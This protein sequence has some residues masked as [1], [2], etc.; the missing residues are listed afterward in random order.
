MNSSE[1]T[2][3]LVFDHLPLPVV[4]VNSAFDFTYANPAAV[5]WLGD[6]L[7]TK[8]VRDLVPPNHWLGMTQQ[9]AR[10]QRG[11]G[12]FYDTQLKQRDGQYVPVKIA[13]IPLV[14]S[15]GQHIGSV[16]IVQN[17]LFDD[18]AEMIHEAIADTRDG[19]ELL[20]KVAS[21]AIRLV[22]F[23]YF[24]V[25]RYSVDLRHT[26]SFHN[27]VSSGPKVTRDV[28]WWK[29]PDP[30]RHGIHRPR[31]EKDF[32]TLMAHAE[33]TEFREHPTVK[34]FLAEGYRSFLRLPVFTG[35]RLVAALILFSRQQ[36]LYSNKSIDT[37]RRLPLEQAV[38]TALQYHEFAEQ[39]FRGTLLRSL[40]KCQQPKELADLLVAELAEQY[41][42]SHV[43]VFRIDEAANE[44]RLLAQHSATGIRMD[45]DYQQAL[46]DGVLGHVLKTG[47]AVNIPDVR[48]TEEL[49]FTPRVIHT[50]FRSE[51]CLPIMRD[52]SAAHSHAAQCR[53]RDG[54]CLFK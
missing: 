16:G 3:T 15:E 38:Q 17:M 12:G 23:D 33:L 7:L 47:K 26:M 6:D 53:R 46:D 54:K 19:H 13:G 18:V 44:F 41:G 2:E 29:I 48:N 35:G 31:V 32:A 1:Q 10:R 28:R 49:A 37:L 45:S 34:K 50:H 14:N 40:L 5:E 24:G 52:N 11:K 27:Y 21:A 39:R 25:S 20:D 42:W 36:N 43:G 8:N 51:L 4:K 22:P 30:F 9:L